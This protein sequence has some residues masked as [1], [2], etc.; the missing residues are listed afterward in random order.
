[1]GKEYQRLDAL[2]RLLEKRSRKQRKTAAEMCA[3][4]IMDCYSSKDKLTHSR[5]E[6]PGQ[7]DL[8]DKE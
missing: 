1:M 7:L 3:Q 4:I 5:K 6:I 2:E 8:Q